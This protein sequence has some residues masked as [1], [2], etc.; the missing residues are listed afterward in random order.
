[1]LISSKK[2]AYMNKPLVSIITPLLNQGRYIEETILS[3]LNQTYD[4][5]EYL[6]MD[7][8]STDNTSE[9][10]SKYA[11]DQRIKWFSEADEGQYDAINKGFRKAKGSILAYIN[12]D[13]LYLPGTVLNVVECLRDTN[14]IDIVYGRYVYIDE[15]KNV[16]PF[17]PIVMN[18]DIKW[19]MRYDFINPSATFIRASVIK[20]GFYIDS[21][22]SHFGDWDWFLRMAK[23]GKRFYFL[24]SELCYFRIHEHSRTL[25]M[26]K[27]KIEEQRITIGKLHDFDIRKNIFFEDI[28]FP[29]CSRIVKLL[30]VIKEFIGRL[31]VGIR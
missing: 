4:N 1:M 20:E 7:G 18:F 24:D 29:W 26:H 14:D 21:S 31:S 2:P 19:L 28:F 12:A 22:I 5:I 3:V 23:A 30:H 9:I 13:D 10:V 15:K 8:G 11:R 17:R 25:S 6:I 27:R 16:L